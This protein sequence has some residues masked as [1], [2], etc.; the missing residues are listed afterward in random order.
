MFLSKWTFSILCF[1]R[2]NFYGDE[3]TETSILLFLSEFRIS[4]EL[5]HLV[6]L[7]MIRDSSSTTNVLKLVRF[8]H[9]VKEV[10]DI[11]KS[12]YWYRAMGVEEFNEFL[13]QDFQLNT[14]GSSFLG[15]APDELYTI[16]GYLSRNAPGAVVEFEMPTESFLY[17]EFSKLKCRPKIESGCFSYGLG[18]KGSI[19]GTKN[20]L[21][22]GELFNKWIRDGKIEVRIVRMVIPVVNSSAL[23]DGKK[24]FLKVMKKPEN[25]AVS[26]RTMTT[27]VTTCIYGFVVDYFTQK[28]FWKR[29]LAKLASNLTISEEDDDNFGNI[30]PDSSD[31]K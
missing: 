25:V 14:V 29:R 30:S 11:S 23:V 15:I 12:K 19:A 26:F 17:E 24:N 28:Y 20:K 27:F 8:D 1:I 3:A 18:L 10:H 2:K 31:E 5:E 22:L 13:Q 4:A 16:D 6:K 21:C 9:K 7:F